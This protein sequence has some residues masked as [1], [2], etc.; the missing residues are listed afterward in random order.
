MTNIAETI[1]EGAFKDTIELLKNGNDLDIKICDMPL[2]LY[3][4]SNEK[5]YTPED[6]EFSQMVQLIEYLAEGGAN[7][8]VEDDEKE[9]LLSHCFHAFIPLETIEK[10]IDCGG[11][12]R[13]S[14]GD[15]RKGAL[16]GLMWALE[17][18]EDPEYVLDAI[19]LLERKQLIT[20]QPDVLGKTLVEYFIHAQSDFHELAQDEYVEKFIPVAEA[21]L[22][23][24]ADINS[25]ARSGHTVL[26]RA[27]MHVLPKVV[28]FCIEKGANPNLQSN[29]GN[30]AL[31]FTCGLLPEVSDTGDSWNY[32]T[33]HDNI[34]S[35]LL[36]ANAD[37]T[38][39]NKSG[40]TAFDIAEKNRS[41]RI[42]ELLR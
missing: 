34:C 38:I 10:V 9:G 24:G 30:T 20:N 14:E 18:S 41:I 17:E 21:L 8:K 35:L 27:A 5:Y 15:L 4:A 25:T 36:E 37:K 28:S 26:M 31:I 19:K 1:E 7:L 23:L 42:I 12:V 39:S 16:S 40:K 22:G 33:E 2:I 3:V 32:C 11:T 29:D 13:N 6:E